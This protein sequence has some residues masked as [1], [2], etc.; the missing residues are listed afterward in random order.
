MKRNAKLLFGTATVLSGMVAG[1]VWLFHAAVDVVD[2]TVQTTLSTART[3]E[4]I[5]Q[6]KPAS[7]ARIGTPANPRPDADTRLKTGIASSG[8]P[9]QV[10][11][12]AP[13]A[14]T[15][16]SSSVVKNGHRAGATAETDDF[17]SLAR[18]LGPLLDDDAEGGLDFGAVKKAFADNSSDDDWLALVPGGKSPTLKRLMAGK[19][20]GKEDQ[21]IDDAITDPQ[22]WRLL[23]FLGGLW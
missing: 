6:E 20:T 12:P 3:V 15:P 5:V 22:A 8:A 10:Q 1:A 19:Y 2:D 9:A 4:K 16:A 14:P 11:T 13:T 21:A 7:A 17:E 18:N 23:S